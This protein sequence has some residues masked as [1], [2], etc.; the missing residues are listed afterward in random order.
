[1]NYNKFL[2]FVF[3][4]FYK[5]KPLGEKLPKI[6]IKY[7]QWESQSYLRNFKEKS[8]MKLRQKKELEESKFGSNN[9]ELE[10]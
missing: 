9:F 1:M 10:Y 8:L 6:L 3:K 2:L 7:G 4:I 5:S